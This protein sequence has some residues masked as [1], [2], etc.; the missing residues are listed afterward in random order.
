MA[1]TVRRVEISHPRS[2]GRDFRCRDGIDSNRHRD[3]GMAL[4]DWEMF[5]RERDRLELG[6]LFLV[7]VRVQN[8]GYTHGEELTCLL[9]LEIHE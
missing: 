9:L 4:P 1:G 3:G 8:L 6:L 2:F 5:V 7:D